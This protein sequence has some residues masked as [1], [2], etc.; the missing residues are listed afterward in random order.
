MIL[1]LPIFFHTDQS[2]KLSDC[3]VEVPLSQCRVE[4]ITF[5]NINGISA[6]DEEFEGE[7][8][9]RHSKIYSNGTSFLCVLTKMEVVK[10]IKLEMQ[11]QL[12]GI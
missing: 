3:D 8:E 6:Y 2:Q 9:A 7:N 5:I 10:R 1:E 11:K 4:N 12:I